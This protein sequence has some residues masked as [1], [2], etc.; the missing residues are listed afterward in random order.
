MIVVLVSA[1][2]DHKFR[3][4]DAALQDEISDKVDAFKNPQNHAQLKVHKLK[5]R[6]KDRY[7]FSIDY[8]NRVIFRW[9]DRSKKT[10]LL[11]DFGD[12]S[13]YEN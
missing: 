6:L 11:L 8:K 1:S 5:G 9:V 13:I 12:H 7:A 4:T 3:K 2:F 10:A